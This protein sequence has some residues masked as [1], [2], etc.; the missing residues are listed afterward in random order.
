MAHRSFGSSPWLFAAFYV[1]HRLSVPRHPPYALSSLTQHSLIPQERLV[2]L[3][4]SYPIFNELQHGP[5][6]WW[7]AW[8]DLNF[9][10]H[11]YQACALTN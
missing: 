3:S 11:A 9:R 7:W 4:P 5:C 2:F 1:L 10:P 8:E 6:Q